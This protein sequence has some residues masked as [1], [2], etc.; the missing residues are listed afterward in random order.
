MTSRRTRICSPL[1]PDQ[2]CQ[3]LQATHPLLLRRFPQT[4]NKTG[5]L[6]SKAA[7]GCWKPL[8]PEPRPVAG[9]ERELKT[10]RRP[11]AHDDAL[12]AAVTPG[13]FHPSPFWKDRVPKPL[14]SPATAAPA[15]PHLETAVCQVNRRYP[16]PG[17][18]DTG[19]P[20]RAPQLL[21][22]PCETSSAPAP[23]RPFPEG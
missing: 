18:R 15:F 6:L 16:T 21:P 10:P 17:G 2:F 19:L 13:A 22:V 7:D 4:Q 5:P 3:R 12:S 11:T 20:S 1:G 8:Q 23:R 14:E 9:S